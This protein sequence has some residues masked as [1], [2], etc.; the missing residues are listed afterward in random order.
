MH[1]VLISRAMKTQSRCSRGTYHE[2]I[3][4]LWRLSSYSEKLE[5]IPELAMNVATHRHGAC[6]GLDVG[7]F[8]EERLDN[9]TQ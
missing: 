9:V 1:A 8:E 5:Q 3:A 7:L 2:D 4:R 6:D